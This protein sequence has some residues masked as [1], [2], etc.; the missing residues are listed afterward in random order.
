MVDIFVLC[1]V[2]YR[3][4]SRRYLANNES[5]ILWYFG[6]T[7]LYCRSRAGQGRA[8]GYEINGDEVRQDLRDTYTS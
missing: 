2:W 6:I 5:K 1:I 7:L 4:S 8:G 3:G